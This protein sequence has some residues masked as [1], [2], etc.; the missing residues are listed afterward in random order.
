MNGPATPACGA[1]KGAS[2]ARPLPLLLLATAACLSGCRNAGPQED[3][4]GG[5]GILRTEGYIELDARVRTETRE[6]KDGSEDD[7]DNQMII[8]EGIYMET[9]GYI[10]HPY[11]IEVT[12]AGLFRLVQ[13]E[14]DSSY[15]GLAMKSSESGT[16]QAWDVSAEIFKK[17]DF[18]TRI[19]TR[20]SEELLPRPFM[21][22]EYS[23]I[24]ESGLVWNYLSEKVPTRLQ[25]NFRDTEFT[26]VGSEAEYRRKQEDEL[27]FE[28]GYNFSEDNKLS[29]E[30]EHESVQEDPYDIAFDVDDLRLTHELKMGEERQNRLRSELGQY[31]QSGTIELE[32]TQWREQLNLQLTDNFLSSYLLDVTKRSQGGGSGRYSD[33]TSYNLDTTHEH[34]L[35]ESLVTEFGTSF[36]SQQYADGGSVDRTGVRASLDYR[37]R[38]PWGELAINYGI[39]RQ[40]SVRSGF[41][42]VIPILDLALTFN[43]PEP[44][45]LFETNVIVDSIFITD[46]TGLSIYR[47]NLDYSI[48]SF[49][50]RVEI[51]RIVTGNIT[52]GETVLLDYEYNSFGDSTFTTL[53]QRLGIRQNFSFGLSPYYRLVWQDQTV[54]DDPSGSIIPEDI[55][56]HVYG[57]E[58][59]D[60]TFRAMVEYEDHNSSISPF[61]SLQLASS[62]S[63]RFRYGGSGSV[64][65]RWL[66]MTWT[67]P[68]DRART[69]L[70]FETGYRHPVA[71]NLF[72]EGKFQYIDDQDTLTGGDTG[73]DLDLSLE[74]LIRS[75]ELRISYEIGR[76]ENDFTVTNRSML[77]AQLK[78]RF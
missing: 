41:D 37:K 31:T 71:R 76:F 10:Y 68:V 19:F 75:T 35:Y 1:R 77:Y 66:D 54:E 2:T 56:A 36:G 51:H 4:G 46:Q 73:I 49:A 27:R 11:F 40:E 23:T 59:I 3:Q 78:R 42:Q 5:V 9:T 53:Y 70:Q 43:D 22:S 20:R 39:D 62:Y 60:G 69:L 44:I 32:R 67:A 64:S 50:N 58:Y 14:F 55:T 34:T 61:T 17:K 7:H 45:T 25:L 15:N 52:N 8:R 47:Q 29:L 48:F 57:L 72:V 12:A 38:N 65:A 26:P 33:E 6:H 28:T 16:T 13:S 74:W 63:H 30:Y 21:T 24:T 18:P